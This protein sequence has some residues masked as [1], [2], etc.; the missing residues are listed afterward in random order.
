MGFGHWDLA[1]IVY[2]ASF[3]FGAIV[4]S[5]LNVCIIRL[6]QSKSVVTPPS[7]CPQCQ[8]PIRF[9][10]NIP[11]LSY[12]ILRGKCRRCQATISP[13][14]PIV[15]LIG[16]TFSLAFILRYGVSL[17]YFIYFAFFAALVV[18]TFIDLRHQIIPDIISL[19]GI[20]AGFLSSLILPRLSILDS[21]LGILIGGGSLLL[22]AILYHL[23]TKREG[24]GGGDIK[25]LAMIGA[26]L[27]WRGAIFGLIAGA[28][29]G[30]FTGILLM[31]AE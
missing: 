20:P 14:Y 13:Q 2:V 7:H 29:L 9:Y 21:A 27:G 19:S 23:I 24:M 11:I 5:F 16:G 4:G 30:S 28:F 26:F 3:I 18:I 8:S 15:E 25:L 31:I 1:V 10:D 17:Q 22:V 12:L 6:P